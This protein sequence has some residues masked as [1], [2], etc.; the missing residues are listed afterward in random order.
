MNRP[1]VVSRRTT[2]SPTDLAATKEMSFKS[3]VKGRGTEGMIGDESEG[4]DCDEVICVG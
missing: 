1:L 2:V 3:G 4:D